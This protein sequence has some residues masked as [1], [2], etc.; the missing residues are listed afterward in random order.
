MR[1]LCI[2][3]AVM[4]ATEHHVKN[5]KRHGRHQS[6]SKH[7]LNVYH[8][9]LPF[10]L[11]VLVVIGFF[12][13]SSTDSRSNVLSYSSSVTKD[14]LLTQTNNQRE[15]HK[16]SA[17]RINFRLAKAAQDKADDMAKR[18]Y[19]AHIT[20]DGKTPWI[21]IDASGYE[22]KK[23][24]ENLAYGFSSSSDMVYGWMNSPPH[25]ENILDPDYSD[26]GFGIANS[27]DFVDT[28]PETIVVAMYGTPGHGTISKSSDQA[29][30]SARTLVTE[31]D[32][33]RVPKVALFAR[34]TAPWAASAIGVIIGI[35]LSLLFIKHAV[36]LRK[37]IKQGEKFVVHHPV[38]DIVIV[39]VI[40]LG[41]FLT[42]SAG[43]IR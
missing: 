6:R 10:L 21:F 31:P 41:I 40:C 14:G 17:L 22:Y 8:P 32:A 38:L 3:K 24:G 2:I 30:N 19:W 4:V 42:R 39:A 13:L 33:L 16:K 18:D 11:L 7:F 25:R 43:L 27:G 12:L 26:I 23:A 9:Y 28:G 5:T 1:N 20:P 15:R 37:T 34:G 36:A 29:V 35:C